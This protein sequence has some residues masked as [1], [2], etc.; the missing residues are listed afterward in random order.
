MWKRPVEQGGFGAQFG[1]ANGLVAGVACMW[2]LSSSPSSVIFAAGQAPGFEVLDVVVDRRIFEEI[3]GALQLDDVQH[4]VV[5]ALFEDYFKAA[6]ELDTE[7][8]RRAYEA[9]W[10]EVLSLEAEAQR[11]GKELPWDRVQELRFSY[12][13]EFMGGRRRSDLLLNQWFEELQGILNISDD[14]FAPIPR[15]VRRLNYM[16]FSENNRF[17]DLNHP[18]DLFVVIEQASQPDGELHAAMVENAR[19][20]SPDPTVLSNAANG[21]V[22]V[23][24]DDV[25]EKH[26]RFRSALAEVMEEYELSLDQLIRESMT[27]A[28]QSPRRSQP[29]RITPVDPQWDSIVKAQLRSWKKRYRV[30][31]TPAARIGGLVEEFVSEQAKQEWQDRLDRLLSPELTA[32]RWPD[33]MV[34][35]LKAQPGYTSEQLATTEELYAVYRAQRRN[36]VRTA[37]KAGIR[38]KKRYIWPE[39]TEPL[40]L[41]FA[42]RKLKIHRLSASIVRQ[43]RS[44]L[45]SR[46]RTALDRQLLG[47]AGAHSPSLFGPPID[48]SALRALGAFEKYQTGFKHR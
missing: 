33:R 28:R 39:G 27:K 19:E 26:R 46:L 41:A 20:A 22:A 1:R 3:R 32:E 5:D 7:T 24:R 31:S 14:R 45:D 13:T 43:L 6:K 34:D 30:F 29:V 42:T 47:R 35:W 23:T 9:G 16:R 11:T 18:I 4:V 36:L 37:I 10:E 15:L 21:T 38:A 12:M 8:Y 17:G 25:N 44:L 48:T 2:L 40:Q